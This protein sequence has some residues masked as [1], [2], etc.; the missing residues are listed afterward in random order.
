MR[1]PFSS[2]LPDQ[3]TPNRLTEAVSAMRAQ[4]HAILDLTLSNPTRAGFE[5]PAGLLDPLADCRALSYEP[6][7]LGTAA[8]RQ[9]AAREYGR[10]RL[11]VP[12]ERI[13]LTAST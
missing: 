3:L 9:A 11:I 7:A 2:R 5:Y 6:A 1:S 12:A 13:V 10:Q 4:G 8:A